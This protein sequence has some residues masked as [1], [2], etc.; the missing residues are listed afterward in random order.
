MVKSRP[1]IQLFLSGANRL[2][3]TYN[4]TFFIARE[5]H[6][7]HHCVEN[8]QGLFFCLSLQLRLFTCF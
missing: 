5:D 7:D 4:N 6:E 1:T 2:Q 3:S 8:I